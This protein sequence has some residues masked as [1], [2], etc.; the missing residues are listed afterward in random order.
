MRLKR[1]KAYCS[2]MQCWRREWPP[3]LVLMQRGAVHWDVHEPFQNHS[4]LDEHVREVGQRLAVPGV[5]VIH[6]PGDDGSKLRTT[7]KVCEERLSQVI[8][9]WR[10]LV[11]CR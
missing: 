3:V 10:C 11:T 8:E 2:E 7:D 5:A 6:T 4:L 1:G 9:R